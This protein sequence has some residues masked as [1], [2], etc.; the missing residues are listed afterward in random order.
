LSS[1]G[2]PPAAGGR[3]FFLVARGGESRF[4]GPVVVWGGAAEKGWVGPG[5][6]RAGPPGHIFRRA[7]GFVPA[8]DSIRRAKGG[9]RPR[10]TFGGPGGRSRPRPKHGGAWA[11][12]FGAFGQGGTAVHPRRAKL[13][14]FAKRPFEGFGRPTFRALGPSRICLGLA[15]QRKR[16][17]FWLLGPKE[18]PAHFFTKARGAAVRRCDC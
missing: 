5:L 16:G 15:F 18:R 2:R 14:A 4:R 17:Q 10:F 6:S 13:P 1:V 11:S 8:D 9:R 7:K 3:A 12:S